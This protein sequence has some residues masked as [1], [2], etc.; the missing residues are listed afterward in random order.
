MLSWL[1]DGDAEPLL[2]PSGLWPRYEFVE[3]IDL[4]APHELP[5]SAEVIADAHLLQAIARS[6]KRQLADKRPVVVVI[7]TLSADWS[8]ALAGAALRI[9]GPH[10]VVGEKGKLNKAKV[11][12]ANGP[13]MAFASDLAALSPT[14]VAGADCSLS[15][16]PSAKAVAYAIERVCGARARVRAS[17]VVGLEPDD[18][19]FAIRRDMTPGECV[20]RLRRLTRTNDVQ[21]AAKIGDGAPE[22]DRLVGYGASLDVIRA[23]ASDVA[24]VKAGRLAASELPSFLLYGPPGTG[25]T[26]LVRSFARSCALPVV[27]TSVSAWF[28]SGDGHLG[29]VS[30]NAKKFFE[31]ALAAAPC[32][33]FLDELDALPDR[34][35][36]DARGRDWWNPL[37]TGILLLIDRTR[38]AGTGVVLCAATN[39]LHHIDAALKRPGRFD[40][41]IEV[42]GPK[43]PE[44]LAQVL[45]HHLGDDLSDADLVMLARLGMG[46]TGAAAEGWVKTAR[47]TARGAGRPIV[48]ADLADA[49]AP[50]DGRS[51]EE[52]SDAA[53]HEA[54]HAIIGRALGLAVPTVA[55]VA[56]SSSGGWT[57]IEGLVGTL[58]R[59]DIERRVIAILAGRA[60]DEAFSGGAHSGAAMDLRQASELLAW[61]HGVLGLGDRLLSRGDEQTDWMLGDAWMRLVVEADLQRLMSQARKLVARHA[62][63]IRSLA[64]LLLQKRVASEAEIDEALAAHRPDHGFDSAGTKLE[65]VGVAREADP[66]VGSLP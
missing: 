48:A 56:S 28:H 26:T 60:S 47:Q 66:T 11:P 36:L 65:S 32:V 51:P 18:L 3:D 61:I 27:S 2:P 58:S 14:L 40:R 63:S 7:E 54:G 59:H 43:T 15:I 33:A 41:L 1:D 64:C 20:A 4:G 23:I 21:L 12:L 53:L 22:L 44:E 55:I 16:R 8:D 13:I 5:T 17:D 46:G 38:A 19:A 45:R 62:Q 37:I 9:W 10:V 34:A 52:L 49:I 42:V 30:K 50:A 57:S 31:E 35:A 24:E 6:I 29:G 25:K 39:H